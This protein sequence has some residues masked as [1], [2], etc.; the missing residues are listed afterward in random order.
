MPSKA[1]LILK[2][3][4]TRKMRSEMVRF[5]R[6]MSMGAGLRR[7]FLQ[8]VKKARMLAGTPIRKGN[9][10]VNEHQDPQGNADEAGVPSMAVSLV[11]IGNAILR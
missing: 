2:G 9:T 10:E 3:R 11:I 7:T 5:S 4:N 6:R 8:K 1:S